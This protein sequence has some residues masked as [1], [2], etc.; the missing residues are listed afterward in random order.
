V[1]WLQVL[2]LEYAK[3]VV[4]AGKGLDIEKLSSEQKA[5][6]FYDYSYLAAVWFKQYKNTAEQSLLL[7]G[8]DQWFF[9]EIVFNTVLNKTKVG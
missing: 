1:E 5:E 6:F 3:K 9:V 2:L 7:N 4:S 8:L